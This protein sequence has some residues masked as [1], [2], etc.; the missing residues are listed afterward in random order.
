[1]V[2]SMELKCGRRL[3]PLVSVDQQLAVATVV[4][5][6]LHFCKV[7][8]FFS[9]PLHTHMYCLEYIQSQVYNVW[10]YE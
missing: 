3:N 10:K 7:F 4:G 5:F 2:H 9:N 8:L 1:M 6:W